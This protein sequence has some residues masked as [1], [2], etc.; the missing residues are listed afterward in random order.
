MSSLG[1]RIRD[2]RLE[3]FWT[4]ADLAAALGVNPGTVA[5]WEQDR[6]APHLKHLKRLSE[7]LGIP[8]GE[9]LGLYQGKA[10]LVAAR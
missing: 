6:K 7:V 8:G 1:V 2:G 3:Q 4:Q 9:L 5:S 10:V